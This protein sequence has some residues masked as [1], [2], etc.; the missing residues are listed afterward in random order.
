MVAS[1][2]GT[3]ASSSAVLAARDFT[4]QQRQQLSVAVL[5][6]LE[7][8]AHAAQRLDVS[9]RFVAQQ[10]QTARTALDAAFAPG[11]SD[12]KVLFSLPV[13]RQWL[14]R[15]VL[16]TVLIGH[17]SDRDVQEL[18]ETLL[19]CPGPSLGTI[20]NLLHEAAATARR[21]NERED[22]SAIRV[23]ALDEIYQSDRP[24]LVGVD[25]ASTYCFLMSPEATCDTDTWGVRLLELSEER[26]LH[27]ER[28]IADGGRSLRAAQAL[29]WPQIPCNG[30]VFHALRLMQE[31]VQFAENRAWQAMRT[32]QKLQRRKERTGRRAA[33]M[34]AHLEAA[35]AAMGQAIALADDLALLYQWMRTDVLGMAGDDL[36]TRKALYDF[37]VDELQARQQRCP[38]RLIALVRALRNQR[39]VLLGFVRALEARLEGVAQETGVRVAEV[40]EV[41]RLE[42]LDKNQSLYWQRRA[43]ALRRWGP[44]WVEVEAAVR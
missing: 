43:A 9:R 3:A 32:V 1:I 40:R 26:N 27:L 21:L 12:D 38:H 6:G 19:S 16:G 5:A 11:E 15:F 39:D 42:A 2:I 28:S 33:P 31:E 7:S 24:T 30:D 18:S 22:L 34:P 44:A 23:A 36:A 37:V 14:R 10:C 4:P 8:G 41:C 13:T 25:L 20:H 35:R 17:A 29:V